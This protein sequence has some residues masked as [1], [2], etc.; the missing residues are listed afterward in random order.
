MSSVSF[1][2]NHSAS[3][4][5]H[6]S[7]RSSHCCPDRCSHRIVHYIGAAH[8]LAHRKPRSFP[9]DALSS[10]FGRSPKGKT[11]RH[12]KICKGTITWQKKK[13]DERLEHTERNDIKTGKVAI[14]F[15]DEQEGPNPRRLQ[16]KCLVLG[17]GQIAKF[18]RQYGTMMMVLTRMIDLR[19]IMAM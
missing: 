16:L 6:S 2:N 7:C 13:A 3:R 19:Y 8:V 12:L 18:S 5:Q 1:C 17:F 11:R 4:A 9:I 15:G 10:V 14:T